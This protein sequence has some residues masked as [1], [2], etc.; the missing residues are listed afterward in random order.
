[1]KYVWN[2][3]KEELSSNLCEEIRGVQKYENEKGVVFNVPWEVK[4]VVDDFVEKIRRSRSRYKGVI[5]E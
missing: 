2:F 3:F 1:M 5:M 4:H